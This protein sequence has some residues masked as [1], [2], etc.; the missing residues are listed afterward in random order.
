MADESNKDQS[1]NNGP[2]K[3]AEFDPSKIQ[4]HVKK[5]SHK[6]PTGHQPS[7]VVVRDRFLRPFAVFIFALGVN[8]YQMLSRDAYCSRKAVPLEIH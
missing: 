8:H 7:K 6:L 1:A 2:S 3:N 4:D 5:L